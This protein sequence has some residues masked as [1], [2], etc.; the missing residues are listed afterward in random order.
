M[1][2]N[3]LNNKQ[4]IAFFIFCLFLTLILRVAEISVL[5]LNMYNVILI[6]NPL[7]RIFEYVP[8]VV[9]KINYCQATNGSHFVLVYL[10]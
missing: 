6:L 9:K 7:G 3:K 4:N 2:K 1:T 8:V 5:V 10:A